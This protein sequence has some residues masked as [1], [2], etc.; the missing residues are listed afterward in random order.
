METKF[1]ITKD[2]KHF[3]SDIQ[4]HF[5]IAN[6]NGYKTKDIIETGL[7]LDKKLIILECYNNKHLQKIKYTN[8]F[9]LNEVNTYIN[10]INARS[11]ES[12][13]KYNRLLTGL[14]EGD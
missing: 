8:R 11:I 4:D 10:L 2:L 13:Y 7:I 5:I 3:K 12:K 9:I 6:S 1:I 14:K